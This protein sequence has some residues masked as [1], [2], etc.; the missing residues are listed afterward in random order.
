MNIEVEKRLHRVMIKLTIGYVKCPYSKQCTYSEICNR[1]N[2]YYDK[3]SIFIEN[4]SKLHN[5]VKLI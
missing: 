1:C 4:Y 2:I 3:C 5:L